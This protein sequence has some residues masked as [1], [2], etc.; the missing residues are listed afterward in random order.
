MHSPS[1][2]HWQ[3]VKCIFRYL[4]GTTEFALFFPRGEDSYD[5]WKGILRL[6]GYN[7]PDWVG[8]YDTR[9]SANGNCFFLGNAC[10]SWLSKKQPT[11]VT[12]TCEDEYMAAF[13]ATVDCV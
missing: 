6:V 10:I 4:K 11:M 12:S 13:T 2:K 3:A 5:A 1:S 9:H 8:D 7:D